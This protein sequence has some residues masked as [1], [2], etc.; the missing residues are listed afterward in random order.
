VH[1]AQVTETVV[2]QERRLSSRDSVNSK[3][4]TRKTE[5]SRSASKAAKT[6]ADEDEEEEDEWDDADEDE[7]EE[8]DEDEE[9]ERSP[10][11]KAR[12]DAARPR[13]SFR[14]RNWLFLAGAVAL[15]GVLFLNTESAPKV[16]PGD[17]VDANITLVTADRKDLD[18]VASEGLKGYRCGFSNEK[19]PRTVD[20]KHRLRPYLTL[21]RELYLIP[22]LFL[23]PAIQGRYKTEPPDKPRDKLKRF[24]AKCKV[25][26]IGELD[27]VRLRWS[28]GGS[29]TPKSNDVR[30]ATVSGCGIDG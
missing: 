17:V 18:C 24:T 26:V 28:P 11:S 30:V 1:E 9:E 16:E 23:E 13:R 20:E 8:D 19:T 14:L 10:R 5:K 29:W 3:K 4:R 2:K 6:D 7:E 15:V 12:R 22:G 25:K 27:N 21:D